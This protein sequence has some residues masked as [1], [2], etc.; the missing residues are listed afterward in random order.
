[1]S[2]NIFKKF[3]N[4]SANNSKSKLDLLNYVNNKPKMK[5]LVLVLEDDLDCEEIADIPHLIKVVNNWKIK[6]E[7]MNF[8]SNFLK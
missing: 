1:M 2:E 4:M 5:T 8:I 6:R 3:I 7:Q